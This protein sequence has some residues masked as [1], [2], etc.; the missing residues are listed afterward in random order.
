MEK[1]SWSPSFFLLFFCCLAQCSPRSEVVADPD[2][3]S[4]HPQDAKDPPRA[5]LIL[6]PSHNAVPDEAEGGCPREM[7]LVDGTYCP[8]VKQTC[9]RWVDPPTSAFPFTRCA[10][11]KKPAVC[12]GD[13][14]HK[15]YCIDKEEYVRAPDALPLVRLDWNEAEATCG[16]KGAHL[17]TEP[18]W[19]FACEG[20]EMLPYPYGFVRDPTACNFDRTDLGKM[21]D[22]LIDHRAPADEFP[23]CVSPFGVHDMVGNV[24][25]WTRNEHAV[26]P[27]RSALHG[28]WWLPGRN[29]CRQATLGHTEDYGGKQVGFR[30]CRDAR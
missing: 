3:S 16:E 2:V 9:I 17:C 24:D 19:E 14:V 4:K 28:G 26:A 21:G 18:E 8:N 11:W 15:R 27:H 29:N 7:V 25:E 1:P 5:G 22:G 23:R 30:C 20:E 13:R 10:E 6:A 12:E